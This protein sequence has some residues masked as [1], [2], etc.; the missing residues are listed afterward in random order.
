VRERSPFWGLM[1]VLGEI[2][3]R[4]GRRQAEEQAALDEK[5]A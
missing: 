4:L 2:A 3:E 5:A 1:L